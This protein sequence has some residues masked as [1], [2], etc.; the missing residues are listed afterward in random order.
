MSF[1]KK[2]S[3][4]LQ[5][6]FLGSF[7]GFWGNSMWENLFCS[8]I[9]ARIKHGWNQGGIFTGILDDTKSSDL[10][11]N[12]CLNHRTLI[13]RNDFL[14]CNMRF[15]VTESIFLLLHKISHHKKNNKQVMLF[16]WKK[17]PALPRT[18]PSWEKFP[19]KWWNYLS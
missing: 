17:T 13:R 11:G 7:W 9:Y 19:V 4:H 8:S 15:P 1:V 18:Y 5:F 3:T 12:I 6:I 16:Q 2:I 14:C 10:T